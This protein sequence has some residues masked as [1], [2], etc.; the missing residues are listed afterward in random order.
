MA[1]E[2]HLW[3][4]MDTK[5]KDPL[6]SWRI[7]TWPGKC[8]VTQE[9]KFLLL[10]CFSFRRLGDVTTGSLPDRLN[11][12][13]VSC[14]KF[15]SKQYPL[16]LWGSLR[17]QDK[18]H[19]KDT[20]IFRPM[21]HIFQ[22]TS[23]LISVGKIVHVL[24]Y[25]KIYLLTLN[26]SHYIGNFYYKSRNYSASILRLSLFSI[27]YNSRLSHHESVHFCMPWTKGQK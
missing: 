16:L 14:A 23:F 25:I 24:E 10:F 9:S 27:N 15:L 21:Q 26:I 6:P 5:F 12:A 19:V 18:S 13:E 8:D 17:F 1:V 7:G 11:S 22:E 3:W 2:I 20:T 4:Y